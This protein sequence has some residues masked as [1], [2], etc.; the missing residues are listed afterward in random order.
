ML[1]TLN[2]VII[3]NPKTELGLQIQYER[4]IYPSGQEF[5]MEQKNILLGVKKV[6]II[7]QSP[8]SEFEIQNQYGRVIYPSIGNFI[9]NKKKYTFG[10]QKDENKTPEPKNGIQAP[11]SVWSCDISIDQEFNIDEE[12]IYF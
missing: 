3:W 5:Y 1:R 8:K 7:L 12:N 10:D 2:F 11:K 6:K 9:W 4:V